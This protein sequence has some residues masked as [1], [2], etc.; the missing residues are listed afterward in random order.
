MTLADFLESNKERLIVRWKELAIERLAYRLEESALLDHLPQFIDDIVT[1]LRSP[2]G[3]WPVVESARDHGR[4]RMRTGIDMGAATEEI[5]LVTEALFELGNRHG[6]E[7]TLGDVTQFAQVIGRGTAASVNAYV[8]LRDQEFARIAADHFSFVA[9][10]LRTPLQTASYAAR[11]LGPEGLRRDDERCLALLQQSLK[12]LSRVVD[13][14]LLNLR[15][16]RTTLPAV[17]EF[18]VVEILDS[19]LDNVQ[20]QAHASGVAL[21]RETT[22]FK[23]EADRGLLLSALLNLLT[24]AIKFTPTPGRVTIRAEVQESR[25]IFEIEDQCGGIGED[26]LPRLFQPFVQQ[27][28]GTDGTGL[29]LMLVKDVA[30]AHHGSVRVNNRPGQGCSFILEIPLRRGN[31][32]KGKRPT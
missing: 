20:S 19:A 12:T 5:A 24:N 26:L 16:P 2:T 15:I 4:H 7:L 6:R 8:A 23:L 1:T 21:S 18:D 10:T 17:E 28:E 30:E 32:R 31:S 9:H 14:S 11:L 3:R 25:A 29:G 13:D 22:S 27:S